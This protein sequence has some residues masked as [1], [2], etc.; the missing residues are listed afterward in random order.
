MRYRVAC[1]ILGAVLTCAAPG[2]ATAADLLVHRET[3]GGAGVDCE[4]DV[5]RTFDSVWLG[6]FTGGYSHSLGPGE[7]IVLDWRDEKLCYPSR[8]AC[9]RHM[10][11]MRREFH[12]PEGYFTC[13]PIR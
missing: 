4:G 9:D 10:A 6:H 3:L 13:M 7:P 5:V 2:L 11:V 8:H 1:V 12:R